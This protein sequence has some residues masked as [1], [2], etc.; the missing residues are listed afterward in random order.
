MR[1]V[2]NVSRPCGPGYA[3]TPARKPATPSDNRLR[4]PGELLLRILPSDA[5]QEQSFAAQH[6][7]LLAG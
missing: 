3:V 1:W 6:R 4:F 5:A 2:R 7:I